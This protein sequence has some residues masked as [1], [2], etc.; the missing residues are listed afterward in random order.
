MAKTSQE[1]QHAHRKVDWST[2]FCDILVYQ[3]ISDGCDLNISQIRMS[4]ILRHQAVHGSSSIFV[5]KTVLRWDPIPC[6]VTNHVCFQLRLNHR[7]PMGFHEGVEAPVL[8]GKSSRKTR[9]L[10]QLFNLPWQPWAAPAPWMW[11]DCH[12]STGWWHV[13]T[14]ITLRCLIPSS[15]F[16]VEC[17]GPLKH[18]YFNR[19]L[20]LEERALACR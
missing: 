20:E 15:A 7:E 2:A 6:V 16:P 17:A 13:I 18:D 10:P 19:L 4:K 8:Q 9:C 11:L 3:M 5:P 14:V 1:E 12:G